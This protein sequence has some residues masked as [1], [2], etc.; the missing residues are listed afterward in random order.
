M[1]LME[2]VE[3]NNIVIRVPMISSGVVQEPCLFVLCDTDEAH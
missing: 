1:Q 2:D 3:F